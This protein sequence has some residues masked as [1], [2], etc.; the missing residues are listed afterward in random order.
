MGYSLYGTGR[1]NLEG[2]VG[3]LLIQTDVR[4]IGQAV[5]AAGLKELLAKRQ[6]LGANP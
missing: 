1:L 3:N 2:T 4:I 5:V 6:T